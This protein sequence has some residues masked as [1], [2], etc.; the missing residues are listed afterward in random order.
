LIGIINIEKEAGLS[1]PTHDKGVLIL[2]GYL[3]A[4]YAQ[5]NP[6]TLDATLA[7]EQSYHHTDGDSAS[8]A[9]VY[10]ILS[11][12]SGLPIAQNF[13]GNPTF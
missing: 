4:K 8:S 3:H 11:S 1:G 2:S 12:I 6:V 9:E 10:A 5:R 13:A 7:F